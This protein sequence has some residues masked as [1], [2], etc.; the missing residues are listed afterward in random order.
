MNTLSLSDIQKLTKEY[1]EAWAVAHVQRLRKLIENIG[2]G[3]EYDRQV[4][5]WAV[6][7]HDWGAFPKYN[8]KNLDHALIS[9]Q[10]VET[11]IFPLVDLPTDVKAKVLEAI[12]LH[13]LRDPRPAHTTETLLLREADFLDF[14]GATG[15]AREFARGS[16][17]LQNTYQ[18]ILKRKELLQGRFT[19]PLAQKMADERMARMQAF[20]DALL[21][22][23]YGFL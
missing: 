2:T 8:R 11:E 17:D 23:S 21:E 1:G 18:Q 4:I 19:I 22:E 10:I 12:E 15:I 9:R 6:Y 5:I 14:L 7:L 13:D 20:L 16:K 3:L